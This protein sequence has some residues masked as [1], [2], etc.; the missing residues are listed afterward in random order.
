MLEHLVLWSLNAERAKSTLMQF[1]THFIYNYMIQFFLNRQH[2]AWGPLKN[3]HLFLRPI[4][5]RLKMPKRLLKTTHLCFQTH[6]YPK[7]PVNFSQR[8]FSRKPFTWGKYWVEIIQFS[9]ARSFAQSVKNLI[10]REKKTIGCN[11]SWM[12]KIND[13]LPLTIDN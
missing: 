12:P 4:P 6:N 3:H 5:Y 7:P 10:V 11:K 8:G 2:L 13:A 9:L 1:E